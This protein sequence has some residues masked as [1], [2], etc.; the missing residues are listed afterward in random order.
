M[1]REAELKARDFAA[2]A[3]GGFAAETEVGVVQRLLLQA[4]TALGSYADRPWAVEQG[5]PSYVATLLE[6][7][8]GAE[9]G[10]DHQLA[11]R[12]RADRRRCSPRRRSRRS[13]AGATARPRWR[14]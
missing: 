10:S 12:Q 4:Q 8:R 6:L 7:V 5:W 14:A 2:L 11:V 1:T 9:A 13:A 3:L